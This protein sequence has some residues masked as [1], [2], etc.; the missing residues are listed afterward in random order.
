ME[1]KMMNFEEFEKIN[2]SI[3]I[4]SIQKITNLDRDIVKNSISNLSV[5]KELSQ[6]D[7]NDIKVLQGIVAVVPDGIYGAKTRSAVKKYQ[8][9]T[10]K[11]SDSDPIKSKR[12]DG[13]WGPETAKIAFP[14]KANTEKSSKIENTKKPKEKNQKTYLFFNGN[15]LDFIEN[16]KIVKTWKAIS[17]RTYYHWNVKP[18]IWEKRYTISPVELS[19]V[20]QEGPIPQGNYTLGSTQTRPTDDKWRTDQEYIKKTLSE[21]TVAGL[22]GA[23]FQ[24]DTHEFYDNT[25][26]SLMAW[27][28][29]RWAI[30]PN[31]DTNTYGR[32][33]FYLHGGGT[34]GSIGC[35]DLVTESPEFLKYYEAWRKK[36]GNSTIALKVDYSTFNKNVPIDV[37]SQPYKMISPKRPDKITWYNETDSVI[38]DTLT[39]NKIRI[40]YPETLNARKI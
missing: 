16:G 24:P 37:A 22:P 7:K 32:G 26:L 12:P 38:K 27:G 9:S 17:G 36:T 2:E 3:D 5:G 29:C 15:K 10:L 23:N 40:R 34:P 20:K 21:V 33:S 31:K 11:M 39:K 1:N 13:I 35:I 8:E 6:L 14:D 25:P 28:N 4:D 19:K 30:I 18:E